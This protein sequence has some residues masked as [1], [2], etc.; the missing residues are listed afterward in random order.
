MTY[1]VFPT[2]ILPSR[3]EFKLM[4]NSQVSQ[5][6]NR[7]VE[8]WTRPGT[9]W[10]M[11]GTWSGVRY[12]K[13]RSLD[14][15]T[16]EL[17]GSGGEFMMWDSTHTQLGDW[18]GSIVVDGDDQTGTLLSI[19]GATPN[20]LIA[21]KGDRFQ[22]DY[23]LYKLMED[24]VADANGQCQLRFNPQLFVVP[25]DGTGLISDNP[26]CKMM[27]PDNNQGPSFASRKLVVRDFSYSAFTS[28][29]R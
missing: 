19:R 21:P 18:T 17:G 22:L 5:G 11:N 12:A 1:P 24:A 27:L 14:V 4:P 7:M 29:R 23:Y 25:A 2:D 3:L 15:F 6:I 9:I 20:A 8:V 16:D 26:M 28:I 10:T 13:A